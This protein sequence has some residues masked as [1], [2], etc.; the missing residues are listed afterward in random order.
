ML[1]LNIST[2]EL[3]MHNIA[4]FAGRVS[5]SNTDGRLVHTLPISEG[6]INVSGNA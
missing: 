4:S 1:K 5:F 6:V 2:F 3:Y